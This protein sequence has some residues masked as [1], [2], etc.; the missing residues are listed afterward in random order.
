MR[1]FDGIPSDA[2]DETIQGAVLALLERA[3][4]QKL[5]S[6]KWSLAEL[7]PDNDDFEWLCRW[8]SSLSGRTAQLWLEEEPWRGFRLGNRDCTRSIAL[9]TLLLLFTAER[10]FLERLNEYNPGSPGENRAMVPPLA[11]TVL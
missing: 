7:Q 4:E 8:V 6:R 2:G 10:A 9:G 11:T 5:L 3:Q 1:I